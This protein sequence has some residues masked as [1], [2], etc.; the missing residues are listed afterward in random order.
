MAG[1]DRYIVFYRSL[2][3]D[4][5]YLPGREAVNA[6]MDPTVAPDRVLYSRL[7]G[8][9][10][11]RSGP[12]IYRPACNGCKACLALRVPVASFRPDRSQ[13][14]VSRLHA[15]LSVTERDPVFRQEH[16]ELYRR[17]LRARHP[18][19]GMDDTDPQDYLSFLVCAGIDTRF[20]E[21]SADGRCLIVAVV[22]VLANG[23][24]AV[25]T[26]YE[27]DLP[28]SSL[29]AY[30]VL[31]QIE[32]ARRMGLDWLYLGYWIEECRKMSYKIRY[33]PCELFVDGSWRSCDGLSV[34][35]LSG[36]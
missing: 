35:G 36:Q 8:L 11:R 6:V 29:G 16:Y 7:V 4:C 34:G 13:R 15:D 32:A 22:D 2:P 5:G 33:Q 24:S 9:G 19:G 20:F 12:R 26:F 27:P 3:Q 18:G 1:R 23:L 10:F 25:Y 14:R 17:Y 21:F 30:A 28:G 31:W